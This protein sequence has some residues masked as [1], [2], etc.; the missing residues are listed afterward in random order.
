MA[1][2]PTNWQTGDTITA[3]KLNKAEQ[4][5]EQAS[6]F[7]FDAEITYADE[8]VGTLDKTFTEIETAFNAGKICGVLEVDG[9]AKNLYVV[10]NII[11]NAA[12]DQ[13]QLTICMGQNEIILYAASKA[14]YPS[15]A[16]PPAGT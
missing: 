5:I 2:V 10:Q 4:G 6:S 8:D 12:G 11:D 7:R 13:Y 1:Y 3:E 9:G 15:T 16:Q 14:D